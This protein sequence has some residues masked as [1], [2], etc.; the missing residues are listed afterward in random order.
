MI[1][2]LKPKNKKFKINKT[3]VKSQNKKQIMIF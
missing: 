1:T 3:V 2:K